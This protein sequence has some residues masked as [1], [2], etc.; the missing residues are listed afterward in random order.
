MP[1]YFPTVWSDCGWSLPLVARLGFF[2][3]TNSFYSNAA[4][5]R[6]RTIY[7]RTS[8]NSE[9]TQQLLVGLST[10]SELRGELGDKPDVF[11]PSWSWCNVGLDRTYMRKV[12][13]SFGVDGERERDLDSQWEGEKRERGEGGRDGGRGAW[14]HIL[15]FHGYRK[16]HSRRREFIVDTMWEVFNTVDRQQL[17]ITDGF[18]VWI[19]AATLHFHLSYFIQNLF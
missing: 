2:W 8:A 18:Y 3:R 5:Q 12:P 10:Y 6:R 7:T 17:E 11:S 15:C 4:R 16:H 13:K 14:V 19:E 9:R 1:F